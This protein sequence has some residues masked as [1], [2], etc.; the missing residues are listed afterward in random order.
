MPSRGGA[1]PADGRRGDERRDRRGQQRFDRAEQRDRER[2]ADELHDGVL[3]IELQIVDG[4]RGFPV[5]LS[6]GLPGSADIAVETVTPV[7][8]LL[9]AIGRLLTPMRT[10]QDTVR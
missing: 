6:H 3:R 4:G 2:G 1:L 7:E 8:L 10:P 9:R 5:S